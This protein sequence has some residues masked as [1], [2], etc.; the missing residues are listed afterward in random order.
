LCDLCDKGSMSGMDDCVQVIP[1]EFID[2]IDNLQL[3]D[4]LW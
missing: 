3:A 1:A 4:Q 2:G